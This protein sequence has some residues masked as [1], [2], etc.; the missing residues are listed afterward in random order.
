MNEMDKKE[1]KKIIRQE[2]M[3]GEKISIYM[4][5]YLT[6]ASLRLRRAAA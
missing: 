4:I 3:K 1:E 5:R 6:T 2:F